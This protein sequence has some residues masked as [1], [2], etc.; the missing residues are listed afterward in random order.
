MMVDI[1]GDP[2]MMGDPM[3]QEAPMAPPAAPPAPSAGIM[4]DPMMEDPMMMEEP[5]SE[6]DIIEEK[7]QVIAMASDGAITIK[8]KSKK[9]G[10]K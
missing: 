1:Q 7:L 4:G 10:S 3:M 8:R 5:K 6:I 9:K 2:M